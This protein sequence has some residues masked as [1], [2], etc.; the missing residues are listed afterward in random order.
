MFRHSIPVLHYSIL[1]RVLLL[2]IL[3]DDTVGPTF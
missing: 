1:I 3:P 2:F